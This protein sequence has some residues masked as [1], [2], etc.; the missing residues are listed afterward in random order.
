MFDSSISHQP[1][2]IISGGNNCLVS[3]LSLVSGQSGHPGLSGHPCLSGHPDL[4]GLYGLSGGSGHPL[5]G[6]VTAI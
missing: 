2:R 3:L 4:P 1:S 5:E 6:L